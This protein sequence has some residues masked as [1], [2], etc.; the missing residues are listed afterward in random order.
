M[1]HA[2][3]HSNSNIEN[4]GLLLFLAD[5]PASFLLLIMVFVPANSQPGNY[6][7]MSSTTPETSMNKGGDLSCASPVLGSPSVVKKSHSLFHCDSVEESKPIR[8]PLRPITTIEATFARPRRRWACPCRRRCRRDGQ[9]RPATSV[10]PSSSRWRNSRNRSRKWKKLSRSLKKRVHVQPEPMEAPIQQTTEETES[11]SRKTSL[12]ST[13][14]TV[15]K[16][17]K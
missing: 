13:T 11:I 15:R 16:T 2:H 10:N 7:S 4:C 17:S 5:R 6:H 14:T 12:T 9:L 8:K 1:S 3:D